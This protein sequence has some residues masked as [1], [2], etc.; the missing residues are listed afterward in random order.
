MDDIRYGIVGC[1]AIGEIHAEAVE[2]ADGATLVACTSRSLDGAREFADAYDLDGAYDDV[3]EMIEGSDLDAVSVCTPSGTHAEVVI[4]AAKAGAAVLCEKPLDVYADRMDRMIAACED[5]G[6]TLAGVFQQRF[7]PAT[8]RAKAAIEAGDLGGPVLGD[9]QVKWFRPQAYYDGADWK[10]TREFDGGVLLSQAIHTIDRLQWLVG[11]V[12]SVRAV[13]TTHDR[14]LADGCETTAAL[15]LR[16]ANGALG[17]VSATTA[18][19]GGDD[20]IE[21]NGTDGSIT[22][23]GGDIAAF[24]V[25]TGEETNYG[26]ETTTVDVDVATLA[27]GEGH[28]LAVEDFVEALREGRDPAVPGREA[29]R[30]VDVILAAK[31]AAVRDEA[32]AVANVRMGR[33]PEANAPGQ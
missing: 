4:E 33:I 26:A 24:E 8:R 18:T 9:A 16:F 19:K 11:G 6:V 20:R 23:A 7:Q 1:G 3:G 29:R 22:L 13:T 15:S 2:S 31:A 21:I 30:A 25:G 5:A 14:D 28:A 27:W 32:V 10:G 17:T 12:E